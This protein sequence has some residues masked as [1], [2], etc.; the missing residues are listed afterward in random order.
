ME[1][2][3]VQS[4][5]NPGTAISV[6]LLAQACS[7]GAN[8]LAVWARGTWLGILVHQGL[9]TSWQHGTQLDDVVFDAAATFPMPGMDRFD[10][11]AF[12]RQLRGG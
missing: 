6:S 5:G 1:E 4:L 7:P 9:L 12:L 3:R 11:D 8:V 2:T 10:S